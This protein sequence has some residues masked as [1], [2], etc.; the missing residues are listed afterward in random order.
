MPGLGDVS[1]SGLRTVGRMEELT[2]ALSAL[3]RENESPLPVRIGEAAIALAGARRAAVF[4]REAGDWVPAF[5]SGPTDRAWQPL[6]RFPERAEVRD[7][8]LWVPL[9][10]EGEVHGFLALEGL[11]AD[12]PTEIAAALGLIFGAVLAASRLSK[13]VKD[14]E[15]EVKA[16]L[17]ELESLYDLGLS[18][19]GQLDVSALADEVLYRSISLTDARKGTLLLFGERGAPPLSRSVGGELLPHAGNFAWELAAG[20]AVINNE[21]NRVPT[22]GVHFRDCEKC[23]LVAIAVPDRRLGVLAVGDK[24]SRD[25]RVLDFTPNDAR[26][27]SLFANQAAAAIETTRLHRAAIVGDLAVLDVVLE[28]LDDAGR[29]MFAED[30]RRLGRHFGADEPARAALVLHHHGLAQPRGKLRGHH[31]A[32]HVVAAAGRERDDQTHRF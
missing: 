28:A 23:L 22:A 13:L 30:R 15:F 31:A 8:L 7:G 20:D 12:D 1:N 32:D 21:A 17:L 18:L 14:A 16:R 5:D 19:S 10:A 11:D 2:R 29:A 9:E 6:A 24:E 26:L 25:G 3:R 4:L 27:L